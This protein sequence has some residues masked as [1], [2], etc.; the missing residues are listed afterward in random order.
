MQYIV[1][2]TRE[3]LCVCCTDISCVVSYN[4]E[5]LNLILEIYARGWKRIIG[6]ARWNAETS[7]VH[8][9]WSRIYPTTFSDRLTQLTGIYRHTDTKDHVI[10]FIVFFKIRTQYIKVSSRLHRHKLTSFRE[11]T[12]NQQPI[13]MFKLVSWNYHLYFIVFR[14][15]IKLINQIIIYTLL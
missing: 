12:S 7:I 14:V 2:P 4:T 10:K 8:D 1:Y 5:Y 13:N 11:V 15:Y 9:D 3:S 6:K